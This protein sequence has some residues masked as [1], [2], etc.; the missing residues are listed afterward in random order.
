MRSAT[1]IISALAEKKAQDN[2]PVLGVELDGL[3]NIPFANPVQDGR[4][5][6]RNGGHP[7][8]ASVYLPS[9]KSHFPGDSRGGKRIRGFRL[10]ATGSGIVSLESRYALVGEGLSHSQV[11][12]GRPAKGPMRSAFV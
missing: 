2:V 12:R 9:G 4:L 6:L 7:F 8:S 10:P 11:I 1:W 5:V 3:Q